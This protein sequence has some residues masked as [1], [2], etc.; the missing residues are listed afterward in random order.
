MVRRAAYEHIGLC[1]EVDDLLAVREFEHRLPDRLAISGKDLA[2]LRSGI[3]GAFQVE[4]F[5]TRGLFGVFCPGFL[6]L[7]E[8][9]LARFGSHGIPVLVDAIC[10]MGH[11]AARTPEAYRDALA[12]SQVTAPD[13]RYS[14]PAAHTK[15][16]GQTRRGNR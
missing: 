12:S 7:H 11:D 6:V 3:Q 9:L 5:L 15:S 2:E 4:D 16:P 8:E 14:G 10:V 13:R 1:G